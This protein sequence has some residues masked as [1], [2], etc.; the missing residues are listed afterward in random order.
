MAMWWYSLSSHNLSANSVALFMAKVDKRDGESGCWFWSGS[1][2]DDRYGVL[3]R[4]GRSVLAHRF[5]Y[6]AFVG[7]IPKGMCVAHRCYVKHCVNPDHLFLATY[8]ENMAHTRE[9]QAGGRDG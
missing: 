2:V 5:S 6:T 7:E 1:K 9:G 3:M 8:K 4:R